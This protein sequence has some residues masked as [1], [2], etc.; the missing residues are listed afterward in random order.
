M[1]DS[2]LE[3][4]CGRGDGIWDGQTISTF[5]VNTALVGTN[6]G[7]AVCEGKNDLNHGDQTVSNCSAISHCGQDNT[8]V[9][10]SISTLSIVGETPTNHSW[11]AGEP[12]RSVFMTGHQL[13]DG[14]VCVS[15]F[16]C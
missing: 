3:A 1:G 14:D 11:F 2:T 8:F 13:F 6:A 4:S 7:S 10:S 9:C 16:F 5:K 15:S 12:D